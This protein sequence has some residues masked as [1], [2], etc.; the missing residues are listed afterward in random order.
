MLH[1]LPRLSFV[2]MQIKIE[3]DAHTTKFQLPKDYNNTAYLALFS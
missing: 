1:T 3:K 2:L